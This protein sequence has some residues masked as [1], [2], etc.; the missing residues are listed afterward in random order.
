MSPVVLTV[1]TTFGQG[2][3][4]EAGTWS[5]TICGSTTNG[6]TVEHPAKIGRNRNGKICLGVSTCSFQLAKG[7]RCF[8]GLCRDLAKASLQAGHQLIV[9][10]AERRQAIHRRFLNG[11]DGCGCLDFSSC[12]VALR[13]SADGLPAIP[14]EPDQQRCDD[15]GNAA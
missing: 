8:A 13:S 11:V 7:R 3:V 6:A 15:G 14:Q 1:L 10:F 12:R 2:V 4:I 5:L 9:Y